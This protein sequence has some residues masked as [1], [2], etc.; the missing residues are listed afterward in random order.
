[1]LQAKLLKDATAAEI[2]VYAA[3]LGHTFTFEDVLEIKR[4]SSLPLDL[5]NETVAEAVENYLS[6]VEQQAILSPQSNTY[7]RK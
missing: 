7:R 5:S 1:M 6:P 4:G 2:I 3:R